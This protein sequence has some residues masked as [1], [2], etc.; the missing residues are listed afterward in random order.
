VLFRR[1]FPVKFP[2]DIS[3]TTLRLF[4]AVLSAATDFDR[5]IPSIH[6]ATVARAPTQPP[7]VI[8]QPIT[9][10]LAPV[11]GASRLPRLP[12]TGR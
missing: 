12:I 2:T 3:T 7:R 1:H 4:L 10:S 6:A 8:Q 9:A 5:F 11:G